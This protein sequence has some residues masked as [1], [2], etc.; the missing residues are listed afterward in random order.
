M[1]FINNNIEAAL[2]DCEHELTDAWRICCQDLERLTRRTAGSLL[3]SV[4]FRVMDRIIE[5]AG[6]NSRLSGYDE[7]VFTCYRRLML[8]YSRAISVYER[9]GADL[10][11]YSVKKF[12]SDICEV[13]NT[14]LNM[15][16][17]QINGA[18]ENP[19]AIERIKL[20]SAGVAYFMFSFNE[21]EKS[22]KNARLRASELA[23]RFTPEYFNTYIEYIQNDVLESFVK[24]NYAA[25]RKAIQACLISLNNLHSRKVL[26]Y[27]YTLLT[28]ESDVLAYVS[29]QAAAVE[30]ELTHGAGDS[31]EAVKAF[32]DA[33]SE[34][35]SFYYT[36]CRSLIAG[37]EKINDYAPPEPE[38]MESLR[39]ACGELL[40]N[41]RLIAGKDYA[42]T[43]SKYEADTR[44]II[45]CFENNAGLF[46]DQIMIR[47]DLSS[48][49]VESERKIT[50][51]ACR[52][53][54]TAEAVA[55]VFARQVSYYREQSERL[56][57]LNENSIISGINE[58]LI[59]KV[60]ILAESTEAF[61]KHRQAVNGLAD[62]DIPMNDKERARL[63]EE[64]FTVLSAQCFTATDNHDIIMNTFYYAAAE[65][66]PMNS[67]RRRVSDFCKKEEEKAEKEIRRFLTDSVLY[68]I[69][70]FEEILQYSV[71][72]LRESDNDYVKYYIDLIDE[73]ARII[74]TTLKKTGI[75]MIRPNPHDNFNGKEHE[76]LMA[77]SMEG[78]AKGEI[79]KCITSGYRLNSQILIRANIIA[80]K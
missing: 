6:K 17:S 21:T 54:Q 12:I 8:L 57:I 50:D 44:L 30:H 55:S 32:L 37:F 76:V 9:R 26:S 70:T 78:F 73:N 25:Y 4:K 56:S 22:Y 53:R 60:E 43:A 29:A 47:A 69:S 28:G 63:L 15:F 66:E 68:E 79:I 24:S 39:E 58:T 5:V 40:A 52:A 14:R 65:T 19:V 72:R 42:E 16:E 2:A 74:E 20:L 33:V 62:R 59:I 13:I 46:I 11:N 67:Y 1:N 45:G 18:G 34:A 61:E 49:R 23:G 75:T 38:S 71:T 10:N 77:E 27:Y 35:R 48:L 41:S 80:A 64:L 3:L 51:W 36:E 7:N 31:P